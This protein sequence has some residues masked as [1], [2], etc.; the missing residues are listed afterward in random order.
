LAE[1]DSL[2]IPIT[3]IGTVAGAIIILILFRK[4]KYSKK[5]I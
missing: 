5:V 1:I 4:Y 3:V 2:I